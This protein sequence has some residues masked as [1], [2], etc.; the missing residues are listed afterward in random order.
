MKTLTAIALL[1]ITIACAQTK[2][3]RQ[4]GTRCEDCE[5]MF[6]GMPTTLTSSTTIASS[7][8][9]GER[10]V[11]TGTIYKADGKTPAPDVILYVYHTDA[12][13]IYAPAPDQK[14]A[15]RHGHLRGWIKTDASGKYMLN[16]IR[17]GAYPSNRAAQ[18][19]HPIIK[20][21]GLS[22]YWI[23]EYLFDDDPLLTDNEKNHQEKRGG[24]GI[25]H[26]T[27]NTQGVWI[28]QRDIILGLNI[29]NY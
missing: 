27:K 17:P 21:P 5:M 1:S 2:Q 3:D 6:D 20:E 25:I 26:L 7:A 15:I 9:P 16:T 11:I 13:G 8:E 4:V 24:S 12:K 19:I 29:P 23:D 22:I 14:M 28:G 10:M 18:H